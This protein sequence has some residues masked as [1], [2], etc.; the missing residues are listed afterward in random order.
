MMLVNDGFIFTR[1]KVECL[2]SL[3]AVKW[4]KFTYI[5]STTVLFNSLMYTMKNIKLLTII[6][7]KV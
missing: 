5:G 7:G 4:L 2:I 1:L 3:Q 6:V